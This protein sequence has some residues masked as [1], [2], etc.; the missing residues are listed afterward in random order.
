MLMF[1]TIKILK[2]NTD[3]SSTEFI[4]TKTVRVTIN[5]LEIKC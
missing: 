1:K 5:A 2:Y 3:I 4:V